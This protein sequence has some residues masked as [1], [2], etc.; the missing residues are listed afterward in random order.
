M[1]KEHLTKQ[2]VEQYVVK[3]DADAPQH[4]FKSFLQ[5]AMQNPH[6]LF[7]LIHDHAHWDLVR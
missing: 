7:V 2:R 3:L 4:K 6:T 5:N 1:E